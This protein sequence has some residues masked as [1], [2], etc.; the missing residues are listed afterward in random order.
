MGVDFTT[1]LDE[2]SFWARQLGP[3]EPGDPPRGELDGSS[4]ARP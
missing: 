2:S 1:R 4:S 3:D